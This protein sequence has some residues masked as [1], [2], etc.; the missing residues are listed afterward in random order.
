MSR[1][2]E[3]VEELKSMDS[4]LATVSRAMPYH[5]PDGYFDQLPTDAAILRS[6]DMPHELPVGYFED[7]AAN[8]TA[9]AASE[10]FNVNG[11]RTLPFTVPP[12]YFDALPAQ[13]L[14]A[15]SQQQPEARRTRR[16]MAFAP[17]IR[18]AAAA[19]LLISIGLGIYRFSRNTSGQGRAESIIA[20]VPVNDIQEYVQQTNLDLLPAGAVSTDVN[21]DLKNIDE[22][23]ISRYLQ[24]T[25]W[26]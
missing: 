8:I 9:I 6:K 24:E 15:V 3:I 12:G 2:E 21:T 1:S 26:E 4:Q 5:V 16:V 22:E 7:F 23:T 20:Q 13:V 10:E 19:A 11:S 14:A 17:A 18:W 25:T